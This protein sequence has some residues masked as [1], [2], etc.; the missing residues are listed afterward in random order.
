LNA[1]SP[2]A[3]ERAFHDWMRQCL[4]ETGCDHATLADRWGLDRATVS[5]V[6]RALAVVWWSTLGCLLVF[7]GPTRAGVDVT[8]NSDEDLDDDVAL[9]SRLMFQARLLADCATIG[10]DE[11][12]AAIRLIRPTSATDSPSLKGFVRRG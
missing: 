1:A 7:R 8:R 5:K 4:T 9:E 6:L 2:K 12:L 3:I 10:V 11:D